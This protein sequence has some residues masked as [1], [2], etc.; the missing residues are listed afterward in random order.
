MKLKDHYDQELDLTDPKEDYQ[1]LLD[2][3][4][5]YQ[6]WSDLLDEERFEEVFGESE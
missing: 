6:E 2:E 5:G 1:L 3:D 4:P